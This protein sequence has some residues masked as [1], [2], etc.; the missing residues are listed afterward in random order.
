MICVFSASAKM[1]NDSFNTKSGTVIIFEQ[2]DKKYYK[3]LQYLK[4]ADRLISSYLNSSAIKQSY[5]CQIFV[6]NDKVKSGVDIVETSDNVN[7]Y[8]NKDFRTAKNKFNVITKMINAMLLAKAGFKPNEANF[9]LPQW[10]IVGIYGRLELR[11]FSHSILP[12]DYFPGLKALCQADKLP[13][14]RIAVCTALSPE[15]DGTAYLL[16]QEFCRFLLLEIK[17]L[18]S[19]TDN[20]IADL[21]FLSARK[22]YSSNEIFDYTII[23]VIVKNYDRMHRRR[24]K[25]YNP[26][27]KNNVEKVQD[28]FKKVAEKRLINPNSPLQTKFFEKRFQRFRTFTCINIVEG[29]VKGQMTR[30]ITKINEIF[31]K[32]EMSEGFKEMLSKKFTEIDALTF[33]CQPLSIKYIK[34]LRGIMGQFDDVSSVVI[35][36][37]IKKALAKL[38]Q[39]LEKQQ[40]VE[41]YLRKVEYTKVAPGKLYRNELI[42]N[43]RLNNDFCPS[44][45]NYLDKVQKS[46]L[47]D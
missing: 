12:V 28:W 32:Y 3:T 14:F 46:F 45:S 41:D 38:K 31:D 16:Y 11:F 4:F 44:I 36:I 26:N 21:I 9:S 20:P 6:V 8:L 5:I 7:I 19:R 39:A 10:L 37:R 25:R 15:K 2:F 34:E 30:D 35:K 23:R 40:K 1:S 17:H 24:S 47:K 29:K 22:K 42:E 18:S 13:D 33:V 27:G 43:K